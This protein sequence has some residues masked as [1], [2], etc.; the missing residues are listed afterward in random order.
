[1]SWNGTVYC[2]YCGQSGHNQR[3]CK[4]KK[5]HEDRQLEEHPDSLW[6]KQI[7]RQRGNKRLKARQPRKCSYCGEQGH[8]RRGCSL[9]KQDKDKVMS[10]LVSYRKQVAQEM[11]SAGLAVGSLISIPYNAGWNNQGDILALVTDIKWDSFTH[12][13][14]DAW[15]TSNTRGHA[16][17]GDYTVL[18]T[19]VVS[20]NLDND[21]GWRGPPK[22][23]AAFGVTMEKAARSLGGLFKRYDTEDLLNAC[24]RLTSSSLKVVGPRTAP[25]PRSFLARPKEFP[26]QVLLS[27]NFC[28]RGQDLNR[29]PIFNDI[30]SV[31]Y[32]DAHAKERKERNEGRY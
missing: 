29:V 2:G 17:Q 31:I 18:T 30:W 15:N 25:V 9:L 20:H 23:G 11:E 21:D 3:S 16:P 6:S 24:K 28:S 13:F 26:H 19:R 4:V 7:L 27:Y 5:E 8:N 1:M 22:P 10:R 32:P 14:A 12:M